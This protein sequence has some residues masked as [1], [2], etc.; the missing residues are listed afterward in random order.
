MSLRARVALALALLAAGAVVAFGVT[1]YVSTR[2]RL[3]TEIDRSLTD[4]ATPFRG[5]GDGGGPGGEAC[6]HLT[7]PRIPGE[8]QNEGDA[9]GAH[10]Q[11]VSSAGRSSARNSELAIPIDAR[12]KGIA[13]SGGKA[14]FDTETVDGTPYRVY[15]APRKGGGAIQVARSLTE[16]DRVLDALRDRYLIIGAA[17]IALAALGGWLIARRTSRPLVRLTR[18]AEQITATGE[19]QADVPTSGRD[20]IGRLGREFATMLDALN[21]SRDQQQR[22]A[23]DAGHELRTPLTSLRTNIDTLRRYRDLPEA[24][25]AQVLDDLDSESHELNALVDELVALVTEQQGDE[26]ERRVDFDQIVTRSAERAARRSGRT[27]ATSAEPAAVLGRPRQ[28]QRA[29]ANLIDNAV[30][31][32]PDDTPVEVQ[33]AGGRLT[34]RDHGPGI[35]PRDLEHVFDRFY[36]SDRARSLPGS[37]LGL[38]IVRQIA[39]DHGGTV[40]VANAADGGTVATMTLPLF[41]D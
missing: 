31:F 3:H 21:Q 41:E 29:V 8:E 30:K 20:E 1:G 6:A 26:P 36:R 33:L 14:R 16:T 39:E 37:G 5:D 25:R 7:R 38:A 12:D 27:I 13:N 22:L 28:L 34:V 10:L 19:L 18:A 23:Q 11:C 9:V 4:A 17:V 32:S 2:D 15:T 40:D 24:T 35:E